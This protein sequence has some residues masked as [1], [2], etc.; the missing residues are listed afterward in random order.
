[1]YDLSAVKS[2]S[3]THIIWVI[4]RSKAAFFNIRFELLMNLIAMEENMEVYNLNMH[5][6]TGRNKADLSTTN[7]IPTGL[8]TASGKYHPKDQPF[9]WKLCFRRYIDLVVS[10]WK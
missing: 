7:T 10:Q 2:R 8:S 4:T 3:F 1:M 6:R 9:S 5:D